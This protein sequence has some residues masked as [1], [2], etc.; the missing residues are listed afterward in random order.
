MGENEVKMELLLFQPDAQDVA[1]RLVNGGVR[2]ILN[3]ASVTL[4]F[5]RRSSISFC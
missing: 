5:T 3:F 2:A 4:D 1:N